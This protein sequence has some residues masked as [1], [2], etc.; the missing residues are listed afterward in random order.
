MR[1]RQRL[2][3]VSEG[4]RRSLAHDWTVFDLG[5]TNGGQDTFQIVDKEGTHSIAALTRCLQEFDW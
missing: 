5:C 3:T 4:R 1:N 2:S